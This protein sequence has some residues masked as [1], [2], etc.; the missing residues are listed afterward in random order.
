MKPIDLGSPGPCC[1]GNSV[2]TEEPEKYY[3]SLY[4]ADYDGGDLPEEG[5]LTVRFRKTRETKDLKR[6]KTSCDLEI[7]EI[8]D[9]NGHQYSSV[10][11]DE[12]GRALDRYKEESEKE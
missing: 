10:Q 4:I 8:L 5:V 11:E 12:T 3:P 9:A 6:E 2:K 7:L 1:P